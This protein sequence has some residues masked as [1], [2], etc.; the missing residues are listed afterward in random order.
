VNEQIETVIIGG[1]H[2]GLTMS[3]DAVSKKVECPLLLSPEDR[4]A[5]HEDEPMIAGAKKGCRRRR[6]TTG[7]KSKMEVNNG[8][9]QAYCNCYAGPRDDG[10]V[11]H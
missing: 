8:T 6:G 5:A 11:L 1:G 9:D 2:A 7:E 3:D 4:L 10:T